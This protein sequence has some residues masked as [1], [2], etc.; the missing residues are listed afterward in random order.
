MGC[1]VQFG[2]RCSR[3]TGDPAKVGHAAVAVVGVHVE[4]ILD[5]HGSTEEVATDGVHDTLRLTSRARG[6]YRVKE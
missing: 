6:L 3:V 4:D 5:G 2:G 1:P